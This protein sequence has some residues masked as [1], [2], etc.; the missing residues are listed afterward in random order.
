MLTRDVMTPKPLTLALDDS[1]G[2][3]WRTLDELSVRHLP[4][5]NARD[6]L[7]G[8]LSDRDLVRT[9]RDSDRPVA[10][11]MEVDVLSVTPDT[12]LD[13]VIARMV[14]GHVGALPVVDGGAHVVGIVSYVDLLRAL[15]GLV[16]EA[17]AD[18]R[19]THSGHETGSG[20]S[21]SRTNAR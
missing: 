10:T 20:R 2:Q 19:A 1:I 18:R 15:P 4:I 13:T 3:A 8:M 11:L 7:V 14:E 6:E 9:S 12:D 5:V 17:V 16:D 21:S